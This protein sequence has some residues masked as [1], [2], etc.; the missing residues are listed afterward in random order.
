M[1]VSAGVLDL[2]VK[3]LHKHR[4]GLGL[5]IGRGRAKLGSGRRAKLDGLAL[6]ASSAAGVLG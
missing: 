5:E 3:A 2:L 1:G 4:L 6:L